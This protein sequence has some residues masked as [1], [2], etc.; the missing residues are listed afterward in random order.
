MFNILKFTSAQGNSLN[1]LGPVVQKI[2][3]FIIM[4]NTSIH[5]IYVNH[6]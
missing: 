5:C 4:K 2:L 6:H 3:L 1:G